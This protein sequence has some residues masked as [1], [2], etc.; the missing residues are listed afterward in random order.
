MKTFEHLL[1]YIE[2]PK[3]RQDAQA[4]LNVINEQGQKGFRLLAAPGKVEQS[5]DD[6]GDVH[7]VRECW[8]VREGSR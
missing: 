4:F 7:W 8:F 5:I 3:G 2:V 1:Q 6:R